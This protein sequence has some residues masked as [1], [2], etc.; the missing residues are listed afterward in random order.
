MSARYLPDG[1]KHGAEAY[2]ALADQWMAELT[3]SEW[4]VAFYVTRRTI[5][6]G[7]PFDAISLGQICGGIKTRDGRRLDH[8]TGLSR[9]A[10]VEAV[11]GLERKGVLTVVHGGP[12]KA[13][14]YGVAWKSVSQKATSQESRPPASQESRPQVV[15]KVDSHISGDPQCSNPQDLD[16]DCPTN[17]KSGR[18]PGVSLPPSTPKQYPALKRMLT[19]YMRG[20]VPSDRQVVE[21]LEAAGEPEGYVY[22]AL[23]F[24]HNERGLRYGTENGP[25][26]WEWF[27][28]TLTDY[29]EKQRRR[30][31]A[32][33][34]DPETVWDKD[35]TRL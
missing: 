23:L 33:H 19:E 3:G 1:M 34:P 27:K 28:V 10:A 5:G 24:L 8:G 17:G 35:G 31:E 26:S 12:A 4:K 21:I 25:R 18:S 11:S 15:K 29:F 7:K 20:Q 13:S 14:R 6:F 16:S 22:N 2:E 30:D 9:Q 32:A